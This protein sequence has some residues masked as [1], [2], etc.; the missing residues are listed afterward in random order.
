M[1]R[2]I[3]LILVLL[4]GTVTV[5]QADEFLIR[6][7]DE[8]SVVFTSKA[9]METVKGKTS[10]M[11]GQFELDPEGASD[12]ATVRI[13]VDLASLDTGNEKRNRHMRENHLET[14]KYP[15]AVFEGIITRDG[16]RLRFDPGVVTSVEMEGTFTVHGVSRRL[17]V[18]IEYRYSV[19]GDRQKISFH[20]SFKVSL[21]EHEIDRPQFLFMKLAD[22]QSIEVKGVA[23][24]VRGGEA[25]GEPEA[26]GG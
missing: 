10:K 2:Q 18:T 20:T 1:I 7:G 25:G 8:N 6:P 19:E 21:V 26:D 23:V 14:E 22:E 4:A 9:P 15:L 11:S 5:A 16:S 12:S 17:L 13:E 24:S 3:N